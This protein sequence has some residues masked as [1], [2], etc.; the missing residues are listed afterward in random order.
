MLA[1]REAES[2]ARPLHLTGT[3]T[4]V[5]EV[6]A[7]VSIGVAVSPSPEPQTQKGEAE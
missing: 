3:S 7:L 4:A 5:R 6:L 2:L 1:K